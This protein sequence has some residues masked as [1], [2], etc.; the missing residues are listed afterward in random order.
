MGDFCN[1]VNMRKREEVS[2]SSGPNNVVKWQQREREPPY[3]A[4]LRDWRERV[5]MRREVEH[6]PNVKVHTSSFP[7][8]SISLRG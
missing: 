8:Q 6:C 7:H 1:T 2:G 4:D 3:A 5:G